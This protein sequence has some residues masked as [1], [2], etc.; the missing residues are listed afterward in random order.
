MTAEAI[1]ASAPYGPKPANQECGLAAALLLLC[2]VPVLPAMGQVMSPKTRY[3]PAP[4]GSL[5]WSRRAACRAVRVVAETGSRPRTTRAP[6]GS[7][8]PSRS[9]RSETM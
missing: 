1:S 5:V 4:L 7:F 2:A 3:D 9:T 8:A 6:V